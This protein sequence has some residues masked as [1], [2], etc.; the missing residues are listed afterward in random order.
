MKPAHHIKSSSGRLENIGIN[1][2]PALEPVLGQQKVKD[3]GLCGFQVAPLS[4][5]S[6]R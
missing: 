2:D 1:L 6:L 4:M 3:K 5:A